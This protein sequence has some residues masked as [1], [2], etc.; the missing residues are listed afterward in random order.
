MLFDPES[1]R[2]AFGSSL[3]QEEFEALLV[4]GRVT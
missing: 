2:Q 1:M 4:R 3:S